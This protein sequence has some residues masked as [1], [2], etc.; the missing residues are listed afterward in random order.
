[1]VQ[2]THSLNW[3]FRHEWILFKKMQ[4][5]GIKLAKVL[6]CMCKNFIPNVQRFYTRVQWCSIT[7][8]WVLYRVSMRFI[9]NYKSFILCVQML[10][11]MSANVFILCVHKSYNMCTS[12]L[13]YICKSLYCVCKNCILCVEK[14]TFRA[15]IFFQPFVLFNERVIRVVNF[16]KF[17]DPQAV[18]ILSWAVVLTW[19]RHWKTWTD[20]G[21]WRLL[22]IP[23][24]Q[25]VLISLAQEGA[26]H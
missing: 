1:M 21:L 25:I 11:I 2:L 7:C 22:Q 3:K 4:I 24:A 17:D 10:Y 23:W 5:L 18:S 14:C 13:Y 20:G 16:L 12:V 9:I 8:A 6:H 19:T 26:S 15:D